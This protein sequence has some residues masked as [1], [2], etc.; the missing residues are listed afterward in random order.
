VT[1]QIGTGK[2]L[3]FFQSVWLLL[4]T[5]TPVASLDYQMLISVCCK[6]DA[7]PGGPLA[8]AGRAGAAGL[9]GG[10]SSAPY[11]Y[12]CFLQV[13]PSIPQSRQ[14][15][16]LSLQSS[17]LDPSTPSPAGECC[18]PWGDTLACVRGRGPNSDEGTDTV[19]LQA[20]YNP[21]YALYG[22]VQFRFFLCA[23]GTSLVLSAC[24]VRRDN[25]Y[26]MIVKCIYGNPFY[27]SSRIKIGNQPKP[28]C[29]NCCYLDRKR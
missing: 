26:I 5:E 6:N 9:R 12:H 24:Q 3:T 22:T 14:S 23:T 4:M 1:S 2:W 20:W 16:W 29:T 13:G 28:G 21:F 19:V 15:A 17:E 18:P 27:E 8:A 7:V 11:P 10:A 25:E